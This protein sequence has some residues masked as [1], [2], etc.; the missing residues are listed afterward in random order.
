ML[1]MS[2]T[3][4]YKDTDTTF[5]NIRSLYEALSKILIAQFHRKINDDE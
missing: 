1:D 2:R 3:T 4:L 5:P